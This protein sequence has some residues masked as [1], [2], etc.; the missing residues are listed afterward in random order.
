MSTKALEAKK[1][2]STAAWRASL[3][4]VGC[5]LGSIRSALRHPL[6]IAGCLHGLPIA[7]NPRGLALVWCLL[8]RSLLLVLQLSHLVCLVPVQCYDCLTLVG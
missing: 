1:N 4:V 6:G 2:L 3:P 8:P 5:H 7:T